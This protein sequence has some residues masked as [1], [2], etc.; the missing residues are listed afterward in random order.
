MNRTPHLERL[1]VPASGGSGTGLVRRL[2]A[3]L[4]GS[5]RACLTRSLSLR[6]GVVRRPALRSRIPS[7]ALNSVV[8]INRSRDRGRL[9]GSPRARLARAR[10]T[11]DLVDLAAAVTCRMTPTPTT[12]DQT[13]QARNALWRP[14]RHQHHRRGTPGR[15]LVIA[16]ITCTS[17]QPALIGVRDAT[18]RS[19]RPSWPST[20]PFLAPDGQG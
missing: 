18:T 10:H 13:P 6:D 16:P 1:A 14:C 15:R 5:S 9:A 7:L 2:R 20:D 8:D 17:A 11:A 19:S 4:A 12:H 3:R